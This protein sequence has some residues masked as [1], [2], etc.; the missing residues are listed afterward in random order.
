[1]TMEVLRSIVENRAITKHS[2]IDNREAM[3]RYMRTTDAIGSVI[4]YSF[5]WWFVGG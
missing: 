2:L 4:R 3:L 5:L 1:M